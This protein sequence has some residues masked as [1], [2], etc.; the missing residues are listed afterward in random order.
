M[1]TATKICALFLT[2]LFALGQQV[3]AQA[4]T[5][6]G[7][8]Y[9]LLPGGEATGL[10]FAAVILWQDGEM[11]TGKTTD[12]NGRYRFE[13]LAAGDYILQISQLDRQTFE[14]NI[15][16]HGGQAIYFKTELPIATVEIYNTIVSDITTPYIPQT[17]TPQTAKQKTKKSKFR[18]FLA[19][20][21]SSAPA[22][23]GTVALV[24]A[25]YSKT[26]AIGGDKKA[27]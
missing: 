26:K 24:G 11:I 18:Q 10:P 9:E 2:M 7:E 13:E 6:G 4:A 27:D 12:Y 17:T 19:N 23:V 14:K 1:N 15:S 20:A 8:V 21:R 3:L 16:L 5:V 25:Y 22:V